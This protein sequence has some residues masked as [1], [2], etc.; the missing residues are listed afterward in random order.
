MESDLKDRLSH[1]R[2]EEAA[3]NR[4]REGEEKRIPQRGE[5]SGAGPVRASRE[6]SRGVTMVSAR[7]WHS[8]KDIIAADEHVLLAAV[9]DLLACSRK[10]GACYDGGIALLSIAEM[11]PLG[12][13]TDLSA[14]P[15]SPQ[16]HV[17]AAEGYRIQLSRYACVL[18]RKQSD[19]VESDLCAA[20]GVALACQRRGADHPK[21]QPAARN[22][23]P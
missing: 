20:S 6:L 8:T 22:R 14:S 23:P 21:S 3:G 12:A 1:G 4:K 9:L 18:R 13:C 2:E 15:R 7:R 11:S 10:Q 17:H 19:A 5:Q 16:V